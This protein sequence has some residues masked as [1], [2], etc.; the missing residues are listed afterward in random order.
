[1]E[2]RNLDAT[3]RARATLLHMSIPMS[4]ARQYARLYAAVKQHLGLNLRGLGWILRRVRTDGILHL[5]N[6]QVFFDHRIA[7]S[8]DLL[9]AGLPNEP[10]TIQ[11]LRQITDATTIVADVGANVG[12]IA[13]Q[14]A[15]SVKRVLAFEAHPIAASALRRS[16]QMNGFTHIRVFEELIADGK[17][18]SFH[19]EERN[20]NASAVSPGGIDPSVRLDDRLGELSGPL[21]LVIDV[22]GAE[23]AVLRGA[24][25]TI[26]RLKPLIVF[27]YNHISRNRYDIEEVR[28]LL[29]EPYQLFRL[30][31]DGVLDT[32]YEQAWNCVAVPRDSEFQRRLTINA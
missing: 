11:F 21:V 20:A 14:I 2:K 3:R 8:Y 28:A 7:S 22:E 10:E 31:R 24:M 32:A 19:V 27:E 4:V 26:R 18:Y 29:G 30:R 5:D 13:L 25:L 12:E 15:P 1:M 17:H 16:A 23:P 6:V 9:I